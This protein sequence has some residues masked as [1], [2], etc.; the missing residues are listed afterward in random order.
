M[1]T[2]L[3]M[4]MLAAQEMNFSKAAEKAFVTPQC[5][6][7][8]IKRLEAQYKVSLFRRKPTLQLTAEGT[9]MMHYLLQIQ[10]LETNMVNALAD[11]SQGIRGSLRIGMPTTR[12]A[13]LIPTAL[14]AFQK[15]Y[16]HVDVQV[17]LN[18]TR[19]LENLLLEGKLDL[20]L[21]ADASPHPLFQ[22]EPIYKEPFFL[23]VPRRIMMQQ[24]RQSYKEVCRRFMLYG[25]DLGAF[26]AIPFVLGHEKSTTTTAVRSFLMSRRLEL[27]FPI[28]V[29][30][31]EVQ[32]DLCLSGNYATIGAL[33]QLYQLMRGGREKIM[34]VFPVEGLS[35]RLNIEMLTLRDSDPVGY[36]SV[37]KNMIS[38][39]MSHCDNAI[40][41]WLKERKQTLEVLSAEETR[42][43]QS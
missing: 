14:P 27:N 37:C 38:K 28:V 22:R 23:V 7:D 42:D 12:G 10:A 40:A 11:I 29:S 21:G 16:P 19:I 5:L 24:Y 1:Q 6:S 2:G 43:V 31:F 33:G 26:S 20:M 36:L 32:M 8:H 13:I 30:D 39:A 4:F 34:D 9:A 41:Q 17:R 18:D 25:A 35:R 15:R 3:G